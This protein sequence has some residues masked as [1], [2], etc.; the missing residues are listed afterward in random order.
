M[1]IKAGQKYKDNDKRMSDRVIEVMMIDD[2]TRKALCT[3]VSRNGAP[4]SGKVVSSWI[5]IERL[6][7]RTTRGYTPVG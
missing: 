7:N 5:S 3:V 1:E 4:V 2:K 6:A